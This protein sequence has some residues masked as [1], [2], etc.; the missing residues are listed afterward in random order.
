MCRYVLIRAVLIFIF[1]KIISPMKKRLLLLT[2]LSAVSF[3]AMAWSGSGTENDPYQIATKEDLIQLIT[4]DKIDQNVYF[5]QTADIDMYGTELKNRSLVFSGTFDGSEFMI[6]NFMSD[7]G[8]FMKI[9]N[10]TIKNVRLA[11]GIIDY[12]G[13]TI[14]KVGAIVAEANASTISNCVNM[15]TVIS[16]SMDVGGICG[17]SQGG[18]ISQCKNF[19][20]IESSYENVGGIVGSSHSDIISDCVNYGNITGKTKVGGLLGKSYSQIQRLRNFGRIYGTDISKESYVGGIVGESPQLLIGVNENLDIYNYGEVYAPN[21]GYVGGIAGSLANGSR[22]GN[23]GNVTGANQVGGIAGYA[24]EIDMV[25]NLGKVEGTDL[26]GGISADAGN[27]MDCFNRGTVQGI[28]KVGGLSNIVSSDEFKNCYVA[29][30]VNGIGDN[31]TQ[32]GAVTGYWKTGGLISPGDFIHCY[33]D[34]NVCALDPIGNNVDPGNGLSTG[35]AEEI[36]AAF[37]DNATWMNSAEND[38]YPVFVG[39]EYINEPNPIYNVEISV[40][41]DETKGTISPYYENTSLRVG[42]AAILIF[43]LRAAEG[44][45]PQVSVNGVVLDNATEQGMYVLEIIE[46]SDIKLGFVSKSSDIEDN[47]WQ[48]GKVSYDKDVV[49]VENFEGFEARICDFGGRALLSAEITQMIQRIEIGSL[50]KG[51]YIVNL[52]NGAETVSEKILF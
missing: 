36:S 40:E 17:K 19:G 52:T 8:L 28:S 7:N 42:K 4:S 13:Y 20:V 30:D 31:P 50:P 22:M 18:T 21:A 51:I 26:V 33:Y 1:T 12:D 39:M 37:V 38:G 45:K 14:G 49:I 27:L 3:G 47:Q 6:T 9:E 15:A 25:Y 46:D 2:L 44:Y 16:T 23:V 48:Q 32:I 43:D 10:A 11:S 24:G 41:A 29:C 35:N 5:K 34:D